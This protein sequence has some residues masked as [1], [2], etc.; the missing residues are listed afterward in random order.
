MNVDVPPFLHSLEFT[1]VKSRKIAYYI[2]VPNSAS[3]GASLLSRI[4]TFLH[5][6]VLDN[7]PLSFEAS[8]SLTH[9]QLPC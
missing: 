7:V 1:K 8:A 9:F 2:L 6:T 4:Y 3:Q 5:L